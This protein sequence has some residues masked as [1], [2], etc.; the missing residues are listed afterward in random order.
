MYCIKFTRKV[1]NEDSQ[2]HQKFVKLIFIGLETHNE[3]IE[4]IFYS[5]YFHIEKLFYVIIV[6]VLDYDPKA[7]VA[8]IILLQLMVSPSGS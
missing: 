8:L 7:Q 5:L 6:L 4:G 1:Y 3:Y 2:L